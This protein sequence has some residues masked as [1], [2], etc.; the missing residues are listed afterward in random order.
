[1]P[2]TVCATVG[3]AGHCQ[4]PGGAAGSVPDNASGSTATCCYQTAAGGR[5][6]F[7]LHDT[8]LPGPGGSRQISV[9]W[10]SRW[11]RN[12]GFYPHVRLKIYLTSRT[13]YQCWQKGLPAM[14]KETAFLVHAVDPRSLACPPCDGVRSLCI[15][16]AASRLTHQCCLPSGLEPCNCGG[17]IRQGLQRRLSHGLFHDCRTGA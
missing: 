14:V 8:T 10:H 16:Q 6:C 12:N 13:M 11:A 7:C 9:C 17:H 3:S 4:M 15:R 1:M 2:A 5:Q